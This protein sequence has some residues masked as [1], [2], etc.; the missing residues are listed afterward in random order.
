MPASDQLRAELAFRIRTRA[1][2]DWAE[3]SGLWMAF[4]AL[5]G[6][7][8]DTRE[9]ARVMGCIRRTLSEAAALRVLRAATKH[10]DTILDLPP[11]NMFLERHHPNFRAA[12]MRCAALYRNRKESARGRLAGV[13]GAL[14]QVRCNLIHGSKDPDAPRD[15]MLVHDSL[16]VLRAL[17]PELEEALA[18]ANAA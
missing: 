3:F 9:R 7:E 8:P 12:S 15:R 4:N 10:I 16:A 14:Y 5:Y 2:T 18:V 11:G 13:A 17:L 1:P 6:G